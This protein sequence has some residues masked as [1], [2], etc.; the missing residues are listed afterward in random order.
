MALLVACVFNYIYDP[1]PDIPKQTDDSDEVYAREMA[2]LKILRQYTL[3]IAHSTLMVM[4]FISSSDRIPYESLKQGL[5]FVATFV[6]IIAILQA[7]IAMSYF[8]FPYA[9]PSNEVTTAF[10]WL[11]IEQLVFTSILLSNMIFL[12]IR[13]QVRQKLYIDLVDEKKQLPNIDTL[14]AT[15]ELGRA[16]SA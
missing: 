11:A 8:H 15:G 1:D 13:S 4:I 6:Y 16:F 7:A 14:I 3:P 2:N 9:N 5:N 10:L 12:C